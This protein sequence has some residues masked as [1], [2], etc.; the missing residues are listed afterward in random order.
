[1][2]KYLI[3]LVVYVLSNAA[4]AQLPDGTLAPNFIASDQ[5]GTDWHLHGLLNEGKIVI[6]DF[7][8]AWDSYAWDYQQSGVLQ[9]LYAAYGPSGTDELVILQ[10]E[11]EPTNSMAQLSGPQLISQDPSTQTQGDW[12][13]GNPF[14][15]IDSSALADLYDVSYLPTLFMICPDKFITEIEQTDFASLDS[16]LHGGICPVLTQGVDLALLDLSTSTV[17]GSGEINVSFKIKNL[18]TE[19][20]TSALISIQG[21]T[22]PFSQMWNGSLLSYQE[23]IVVLNNL[24]VNGNTEIQVV[25]V[26]NDPNTQ[27]NTLSVQSGVN[28]TSR[29]ILFKLGLDEYPNEVSWE[30][31]NSENNI[32][33]SEG[34][35]TVQYQYFEDTLVMP[36]DGCYTFYLYDESGDGLHGSQWGGYDGSCYITGL[37][38]LG[39]EISTIFSYDGSTNFPDNDTTPYFLKAEFEAFTALDV[40]QESKKSKM[41]IYPNPANTEVNI[42]FGSLD[43]KQVEI[44]VWNVSG[45]R[46]LYMPSGFFSAGARSQILET[47]H[48]PNGLYLVHLSDL[49]QETKTKLVISHH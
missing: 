30:I 45:Q 42:T 47:G 17:C 26:S 20:L 33:F 28:H 18:G 1:M 16:A 40:V 37:N 3:L 4:I 34:D 38:G 25:M 10:I 24:P 41:Q 5:N 29:K 14:A 23:E 11:S 31:R 49:Q 8:G 32:V 44:S 15:V 2:K 48:L 22:E 9:Q 6:L 7:F 13:T 39:Q 27:N 35:F 43:S 36:E 21:L 46:V 19:E 12:L